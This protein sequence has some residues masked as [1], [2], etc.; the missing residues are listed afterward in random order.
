MKK[1]SLLF[2]SLFTLSAFAQ[3]SVEEKKV[4]IDGSKN[5]FYVSIPYGTAKDIEKE[6]KE[7]LKDW[8]GKFSNKDYIFADNCKL[9][10][11]GKNTFDVFA[12]VE[13][14]PDGGAFVSVAVDLGGAFLNSNEHSAQA[15][16]INARL[17]KFG[18]KA[19]KSVV[20]GEIKAEEKLLKDRQGE[21]KDLE[22]EQE[23]KEKEIEDFKKKIAENEKAIEEL[24]KNQESK[25]DEIKDQEE[26]LKKVEQKKEAVK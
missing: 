12:K 5:G 26:K 3:V 21:L 1:L 14:N 17:H 13:E 20:D 7:E 15:K 9:K 24:K 18:V 2:I 19:A 23:K 4:N 25:N 8:K 22:K 6:L 16:I 11:M 10:E